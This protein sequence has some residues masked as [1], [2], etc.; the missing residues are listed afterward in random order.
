VP[1]QPTKII[2]HTYRFKNLKGQSGNIP[3]Q[4]TGLFLSRGTRDE[5]VPILSDERWPGWLWHRWSIRR[6]LS[7]VF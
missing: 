1:T 2:N 5:T 4:M 3:Q 6:K 7:S